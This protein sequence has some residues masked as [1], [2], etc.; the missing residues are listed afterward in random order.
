MKFVYHDTGDWVRNDANT[1]ATRT[2]ASVQEY[3]SLD[4]IKNQWLKDTFEWMVKEGLHVTQ[5]G[6]SVLQIRS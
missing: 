2:E 6:S 3:D 4:A 5:C 1:R